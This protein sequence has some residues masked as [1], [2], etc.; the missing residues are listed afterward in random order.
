MRQ[1]ISHKNKKSVLITGCAGFI[2]SNFSQTFSVEFPEYT[3]VGIDDFSTG[4]R[5]SINKDLVFYEGSILDEKLLDTI[6]KKH[7]PEYVFHFAALPRISYSVQ[8]PVRTSE[9]N[10]TGTVTLLEKSKEYGVKRFIF[11]SSSSVY[12]G[13]KQFPTREADNYPFPK[14]PYAAQ[15]YASEIFCKQF[16]ELFGLDTI[17]LRYFTVFGPGQ[18]GHAPT[19]TLISAWLESLYFPKNK[20]G[21]IEGNGSQTRDFCYIDNVV[22]AN[23]LAMR[24][25]QSFLG[26]VFNVAHSERTSI[27]KI[28]KLIEKYSKRKLVLEKLPTRKGDVRHTHAS[29]SKA[30]RSLG[31][32]PKVDFETGLKR[33]IE[34][35]E[36]RKH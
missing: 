35:F 23:I 11:S 17:C 18:Y 10:I 27:L 1:K 7:K 4:R 24:S 33:T 21:F 19:A 2:G 25:N 28:K 31:Y 3:M 5:D 20:K 36:S 8:H 6:F 16:S 29:I 30:R 15:K 22:H 34:W 14:S 26:G 9:V 32:T 12:G 13:A